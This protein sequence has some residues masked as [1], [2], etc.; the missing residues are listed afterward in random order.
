MNLRVDNVDTDL[1]AA[2]PS[3]AAASAPVSSSNMNSTLDE[4]LLTLQK[5]GLKRSLRTVT[6]RRSG[7]VQIEN[8][9]VADFASND[10]LGLAAD[11]RVG[12]AATAVLQAEGTGRIQIDDHPDAD[13]V[14]RD[15][16]A[17]VAAAVIDNPTTVGHTLN[18]NAG[19][20]PIVEAIEQFT[21]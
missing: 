16:V 1:A 20:T 2:A 18:F 17:A 10:Y 3:A 6:Q 15:D 12:R 13:S 8:D 19:P 7:T 4:E 9:R 14:S 5:A 21:A 11:A